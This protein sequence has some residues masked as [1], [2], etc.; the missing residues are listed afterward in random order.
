MAE[1]IEY[2]SADPL[3]DEPVS[4]DEVKAQARIDPDLTDDDQLIQ[5][6][7]APAARQLAETRTGTAIRP[8]RYRQVLPAFPHHGN[9]LVLAIGGVMA[10]ESITYAAPHSAGTRITLDPGTVEMVV[11]D[12]ETVLSPLSDRWPHAGRGPRAVEVV[13]TAGIDPQAFGDRAP[14]VKTWILMA[15][16]WA[17]AQRELFLLQTRGSGF[18][19]LPPDYLSGLLD[20]LRLPPRW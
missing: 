8:A 4:V 1:L 3:A 2:L 7:I 18:Q 11:I 20:P 10:L 13:Y 5:T 16:A 19:E 14:S 6:V 15:C 9:P 12:R 17:Y